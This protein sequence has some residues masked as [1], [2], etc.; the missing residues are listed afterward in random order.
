MLGQATGVG[1]PA[2][3]VGHQASGPVGC[4]STLE[5]ML[6]S[7]D[8]FSAPKAD[9]FQLASGFS[10]WK[11]QQGIRERSWGAPSC[12]LPAS[13]RVVWSSDL[14]NSPA[15]APLLQDC[16]CC[17]G[18]SPL[19]ALALTRYP[20]YLPSSSIGGWEVCHP[21]A[22]QPLPLLPLT[23]PTPLWVIASLKSL[24]LN[25]RVDFC[26]QLGSQWHTVSVQKLVASPSGPTDSIN[27]FSV[28]PQLFS[29]W[30]YHIKKITV[31]LTL[32]YHKFR[33]VAW[34]YQSYISNKTIHP[35]F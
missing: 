23:L 30:L 29:H 11:A 18:P 12:P 16:S 6:P 33:L 1:R 25:F 34:H 13:V 32:I 17:P 24:H 27:L 14:E 4:P 10:Q 31:N 5:L 28:E 7:T 9:P 21:L 35:Q 3:S 19:Q 26:F 15:V 2:L 22:S 20:T 8:P